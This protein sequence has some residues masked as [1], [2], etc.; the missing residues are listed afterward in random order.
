MTIRKR[1]VLVVIALFAVVEAFADWKPNLESD[2]AKTLE[3]FKTKNPNLAV[4]FD[5][6]YAYAVFPEITKA[7]FNIGG[8]YGNGI[9]YEKNLVAGQVTMMQLTAG[10]QIGGQ[11]YSE[12]IFFKDKATLD[13]LKQG[14]LEFGANASAIAEKQ[15]VAGSVEF[16]DGIAVFTLSKIGLM[17]EASIGGQRFS[18]EQKAAEP[19]LPKGAI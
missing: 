2:A 3:N 17:L 7:A 19:P 11:Q 9:V 5:Q 12:I 15:G 4:Y 6:A 1:I 8:A 14:K 16:S 13:R 10:L 18:F